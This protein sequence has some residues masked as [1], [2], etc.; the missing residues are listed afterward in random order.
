M[1]VTWLN[2]PINPIKP[3]VFGHS[4]EQIKRTLLYIIKDRLFIRLLNHKNILGVVSSDNPNSCL[5]DRIKRL[6]R[7]TTK[8]KE[9]FPP[10]IYII[11]YDMLKVTNEEKMHALHNL[12]LIRNL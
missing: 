6:R 9:I 1:N 3:K 5:D 7:F 12:L 8:T 4:R 2:K 10:N 11:S